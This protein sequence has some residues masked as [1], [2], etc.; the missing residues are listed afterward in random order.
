[1]ELFSKITSLENIFKLHP[2]TDFS[3]AIHIFIFICIL[4]VWSYVFDFYVDKMK[5][6]NKYLYKALKWNSWIYRWWFTSIAIVML[7]SR[8][9][10]IIILNMKFWWI[11]YWI[12]F[13]WY[14]IALIKRVNKNYKSRL[15][16]KNKLAIWQNDI[17]KYLPKKNIKK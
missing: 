5:E 16:N 17:N 10:W 13:L 2:S 3:Y 7:I 11:I 8:L 15:K 6:S 12:V 14:T 4:F 1:M 9:E